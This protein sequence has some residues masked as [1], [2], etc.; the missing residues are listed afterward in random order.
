M[1]TFPT[2]KLKLYLLAFFIS[3]LNMAYADS[4][5]NE[6]VGHCL[7]YCQFKM[8]DENTNPRYLSPQAQ[9][10][11]G[12]YWQRITS[13]IR[14]VKERCPIVNNACVK[15][16]LPKDDAEIMDAYLWMLNLARRIDGKERFDLLDIG[17]RSCFI[18]E[19]K[20]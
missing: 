19:T 14:T 9:Y 4:A 15:R 6:L 17:N 3:F 7:A 20:Y 11:S 8:T 12:I 1:K 18:L 16:V 13:L 2:K 5:K 10:V